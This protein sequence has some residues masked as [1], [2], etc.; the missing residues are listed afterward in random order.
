MIRIKQKLLKPSICEQ[1][2]CIQH[3][4]KEDYDQLLQT[5]LLAKIIQH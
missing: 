1:I 5:P 2:I 4:F 3:L